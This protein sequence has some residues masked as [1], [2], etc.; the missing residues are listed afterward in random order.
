MKPLSLF[1]EAAA[2]VFQLFLCA[3]SGRFS[4]V[5]KVIAG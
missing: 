5:A 3:F 1:H 4:T 2:V